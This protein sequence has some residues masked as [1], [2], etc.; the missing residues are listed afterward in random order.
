MKGKVRL[1]HQMGFS[2]PLGGRLGRRCGRVCSG[3]VNCDLVFLS[4]AN[5]VQILSRFGLNVKYQN[6]LT[7]TYNRFSKPNA[8]QVCASDA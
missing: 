5:G 8:L 2:Y 1:I 3:R 4:T 7:L 6:K